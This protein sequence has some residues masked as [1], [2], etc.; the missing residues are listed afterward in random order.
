MIFKSNV[1]F[2][3]L[4]QIF[5]HLEACGVQKADDLVGQ[6]YIR[7]FWALEIISGQPR[8][9]QGFL[10]ILHI[11]VADSRATKTIDPSRIQIKAMC[12]PLKSRIKFL[13]FTVA[14]CE[15]VNQDVLSWV[16]A[17]T[18]SIIVYSSIDSTTERVFQALLLPKLDTIHVTDEIVEFQ[19]IHFK[20]WHA[21][22][23]ILSSLMWV[24]I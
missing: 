5:S 19:R 10:V 11:E 17:Q 15:T 1:D 3:C 24:F 2:C 4:V 13:E 20:L 22:L 23:H 9:L 18:L 6:L 16:L 12:V 21:E 8:V 7:L 14:D